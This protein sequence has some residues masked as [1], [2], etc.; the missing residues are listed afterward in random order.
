MSRHPS[1][2]DDAILDAA[3]RLFVEH[4]ASLPVQTIAD[5]VGL[6]EAAIYKR[7]ATK[8][9]LMRRALAPPRNPAFLDVLKTVKPVTP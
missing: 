8:S 4:G 5:D 9:A 1:L 3:R 6:S 2:S 7:F